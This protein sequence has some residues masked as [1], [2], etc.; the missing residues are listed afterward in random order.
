MPT[1][2]RNKFRASG[3]A[4]KLGMRYRALM[5]KHPFLT[6]GLPFMAVVIAGSFVLTPATAV[7]YERHDRKVRQMTKEEELGVRRSARKVD[8]RE[9]YYVSFRLPMQRRSLGG[10][11]WANEM[12]SG[13]RAGTWTTGSRS[14]WSDCRARATASC[15]DATASFCPP[16]RRRMLA[17]MTGSVPTSRQDKHDI[18]PSRPAED[19]STLLVRNKQPGGLRRGGLAP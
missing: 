12:H 17:E 2:Q 18:S 5:N 3:D 8:M 4:S 15:D 16:S 13:S 10:E 7:R 19:Q 9:E 6:F 14:A 11:C 1:F